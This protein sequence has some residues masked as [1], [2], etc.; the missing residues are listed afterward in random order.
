MCAIRW[1]DSHPF[2][3]A[4]GAEAPHRTR[5]CK[6]AVNLAKKLFKTFKLERFRKI[7]LSSP[8]VQCS[9]LL[10]WPQMCAVL[11]II[12]QGVLCMLRVWIYENVQ[13][14]LY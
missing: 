13:V 8:D 1:Q 11:T 9:Q 4:A 3:Q 5:T 6:T 7:Y 14:A 12:L 10:S 2:L